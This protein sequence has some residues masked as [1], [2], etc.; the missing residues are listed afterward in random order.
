MGTGLSFRL[1]NSFSLNIEYFH[2]LNKD[3]SLNPLQL[4]NPLS[5][6]FDM[7]NRRTCFSVDFYQLHNHD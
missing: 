5:F 6:G 4:Y 7:E 3:D 1:T 2:L